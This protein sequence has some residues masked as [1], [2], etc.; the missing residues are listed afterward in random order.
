MN[1]GRFLSLHYWVRLIRREKYLLNVNKLSKVLR[2]HAARRAFTGLDGQIIPGYLLQVERKQLLETL[3]NCSPTARMI[4]IRCI[5]TAALRKAGNSVRVDV[6]LCLVTRRVKSPRRGTNWNNDT[7][8]KVTRVVWERATYVSTLLVFLS[9]IK[10][11]PFFHTM[12][13]RIVIL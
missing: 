12:F 5:I 8:T 9:T 3:S 4:S 6:A 11:Y 7:M 2:T 10:E 1:S 13:W